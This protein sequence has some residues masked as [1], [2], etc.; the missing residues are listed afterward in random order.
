MQNKFPQLILAGYGEQVL[1]DQTG[2]AVLGDTGP[3]QRTYFSQ[4]LSSNYSHLAGK[5]N[6]KVGATSGAC[7]R[8]SSAGLKGL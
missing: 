2:G 5:H 1:Q 6:V 4:V 7:R 8:T 3:S